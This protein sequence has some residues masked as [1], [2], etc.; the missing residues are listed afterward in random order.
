MRRTVSYFHIRY[1]QHL[2]LNFSSQESETLPVG[3]ARKPG[4]Q[5]H[6]RAFD[7]KCV[8]S[9]NSELL[10]SVFV[11]C[12]RLTESNPRRL[13]SAYHNCDRS[14]VRTKCIRIHTRATS[15]SAAASH[16]YIQHYMGPRVCTHTHTN[17]HT[18]I[19]EHSQ[20]SS[21]QVRCWPNRLAV[22]AAAVVVGGGNPRDGWR[23][24]QH[25]HSAHATT[26]GR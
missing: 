4:K 24:C 10:R 20:T 19:L 16:T 1:T 13:A 23:E 22:S 15:L 11:R 5:I 21:D 9:S 25:L 17:T 2:A 3:P 8:T 14:S 26:C 6:T 12:L 18:L 7:W